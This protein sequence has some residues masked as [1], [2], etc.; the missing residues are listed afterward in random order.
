MRRTLLIGQ[1]PTAESALASLLPRFH[2]VGLVR[3]TADNVAA[4]ARRH[5]VDV[6]EDASPEGVE[7]A[8]RQRAPDAVV[9]SSYDRILPQRLL[10]CCP[11]VN[12]HYAPLPEYRGRAT[13]N[14]AIINRRPATAMTVHRL[15]AEL[16][17]GPILIQRAVDIGAR[18]T[19][20][21]VY[22]RLNALQELHLGAAV[23]RHL[24][25]DP[26]TPQH[27]GEETYTC[28]RVP[29]DGEIDWNRPTA[30]VD[31]LV[32]ALTDPF[33]GAF[34]YLE[35][36]RLVIWRA[37]PP[38][39]P[40]RW[41]GRV[42]GRVVGRS[43]AAGWVDV[44]TGD[45]VLRLH[46]VQRD[47]ERPQRAADVITSVRATLGLRATDLLDRLQA[48]E[49]RLAQA[50][51]PQPRDR[52]RAR[53]RARARDD[54]EAAGSAPRLHP[55]RQQQLP[56]ELDQR[57]AEAIERHRLQQLL[58]TV[59]GLLGAR[60]AEREAPDLRERRQHRQQRTTMP[61]QAID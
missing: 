49:D 27:A 41:A 47:G 44:L 8:V 42:P 59:P 53:A 46:T 32:R 21:D 23:E 38:E 17:A 12:V 9:V 54:Y 60:A 35:T 22:A 25:G 20:T 15:V 4:Q 39:S 11:F 48:L 14:W 10:E 55:F 37:A 1:G 28:T 31:A 18:D 6:L 51:E 52:A 58:E 57:V 40:R 2:V 33:P 7:A 3:S 36:H 56:D 16:D 34:T 26:G 50:S 29:G 13:V 5:G 45:G 19:V 30:D 43:T 61:T 24:D